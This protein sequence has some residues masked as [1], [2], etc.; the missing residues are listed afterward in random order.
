MCWSRG[1]DHRDRFCPHSLCPPHPNISCRS[2]EALWI[3]NTQVSN[4]A[5]LTFLV[6][7]DS[8]E[9]CWKLPRSLGSEY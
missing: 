7:D 4:H 3:K 2:A 6:P 5:L 9:H 8:F 1:E